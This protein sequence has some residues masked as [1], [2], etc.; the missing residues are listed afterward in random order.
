MDTDIYGF[1]HLSFF[2]AISW[3][4]RKQYVTNSVW[5][6]ISLSIVVFMNIFALFINSS[7]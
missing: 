6:K 3:L 1:V 7:F 5:V 4:G 2:V